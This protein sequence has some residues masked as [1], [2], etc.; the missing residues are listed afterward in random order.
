[1]FGHTPLSTPQRSSQRPEIRNFTHFGLVVEP[2]HIITV[3]HLTI[4]VRGTFRAFAALRCSRSPLF[5]PAVTNANSRQ[6]RCASDSSVGIKG[7]E[8]CHSART[9]GHPLMR[10]S[11]TPRQTIAT[12]I[13]RFLDT[14]SF[15]MYFAPSVPTT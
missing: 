6:A 14:C 13:Q 5:T 3:S 11:A 8:A 12:P 4:V 9:R 1:M 7:E 10:T 15:N 2:N